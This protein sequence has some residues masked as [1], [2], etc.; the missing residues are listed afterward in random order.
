M[1]WNDKKING[2]SLYSHYRSIWFATCYCIFA[3]LVTHDHLTVITANMFT[4]GAAYYYRFS[5]L[6]SSSKCPFF[7]TPCND[8]EVVE[9]VAT[10]VAGTTFAISSLRPFCWCMFRSLL[11]RASS[12]TNR[13]TLL[14]NMRRISLFY[15]L[16]AYMTEQVINC[17]H[18]NINSNMII[19]TIKHSIHI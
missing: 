10:A 4:A 16:W 2:S 15:G 9:V 6:W 18:P 8:C 11:Y 1:N 17:Y 12:K 7:A 13:H 5:I 19:K 14:M 3:T